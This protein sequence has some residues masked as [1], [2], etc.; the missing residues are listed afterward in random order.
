MPRQSR[1][2]SELRS[3][4]D[5]ATSWRPMQR[6]AA[7]VTRPDPVAADTKAQVA[8]IVLQPSTPRGCD[9]RPPNGQ[10][11]GQRHCARV[12]HKGPSR[13]EAGRSAGWHKPVQSASRPEAEVP[14]W[15]LLAVRV[16]QLDPERWLRPA[17]HPLPLSVALA[18]ERT[19]GSPRQAKDGIA[20]KTNALPH[21]TQGRTSPLIAERVPVGHPVERT[22]IEAGSRA[23]RSYGQVTD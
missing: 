4:G 16:A 5:K 15:R 18:T 22:A 6:C 11:P 1:I 8:K 14:F 10:W 13:A 12:A 2:S 9:G 7:T 20:C 3:S 17:K 23:S 21:Q 19:Y